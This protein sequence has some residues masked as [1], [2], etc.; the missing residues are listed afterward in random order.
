MSEPDTCTWQEALRRLPPVDDLLRNS[1][2]ALLLETIRREI[3][4]GWISGALDS[5][6][7]E[8]RS[9]GD[10][11]RLSRA[12]LLSL[13]VG[14]ILRRADG[15]VAAGPRR[16]INGTGILV[17]TNLGRSPLPSEALTAI[18]RELGGYCSLEYDLETGDRGHRDSAITSLLQDLL[19]CGDAT[20]VNNNAAA[21][22]LALSA[23]AAGGEV[24]VSRGELVEIGGSF[25]IPDIM[26][27]AGVALREVGTTNR[28]RI[29]DYAEAINLDT[30]LLVQ[31]HRS[32]FEL[33]GFTETPS[34]R[35]L[36]DLA[37]ERGVPLLVD[38]GSGYLRSLTEVPA[39][40]EPV[41]SEILK[42]GANLV[43]FSGDKLMGGPQAGILAGDACLIARIRRHP[44]MRAIRLDKLVLVALVETLRAWRTTCP[45]SRL[46]L[47]QMAAEPQA[48]LARRCRS[49]LR[50][51]LRLEPGLT[52]FIS[53]LPSEAYLGGGS[54]PSH[55]LPSFA[56]SLTGTP[57]AGSALSRFL[58]SL[59][60]PVIGRLEG[61]RLLLDLRAVR[62]SE[63]AVL[64]ESIL[65]AFRA[66]LFPG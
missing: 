46:P 53:I 52:P 40:G 15:Q 47:L 51:L 44:L 8:I 5:L 28:T 65:S 13:A 14:R 3:V 9:G 60:I 19:C 32:N 1:E 41:V 50:R 21:L 55:R 16:V 35:E 27:Q 62:P 23:L 39:P 4:L 38:A 42:A 20:A 59:D 17:H 54:T 48:A 66:G 33:T 30:R 18:T 10:A 58:R 57:C 63:E 43:C 29:S 22:L 61:G 49:L 11:A 12:D 25:R 2:I 45:S 36:A 24:I 31:V 26:A 34:V 56:L 37:R 6:R 7:A 64:C